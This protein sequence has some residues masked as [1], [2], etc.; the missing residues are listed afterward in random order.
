MKVNKHSIAQYKSL[1]LITVYLI[2]TSLAADAIEL[3][4]LKETHQLSLKITDINYPNELLNKELNS[5]LKSHFH[6]I[7][8]FEKEDEVLTRC[9]YSLNVTYDLW[10]EYYRIEKVDN[11]GSAAI[12]R[13][14]NIQEVYRILK[15][16][17]IKCPLS[18]IQTT[19]NLRIKAQVFVNPVEQKRIEKIKS[20]INTSQEHKDGSE[21][22]M[23]HVNEGSHYNRIISI[24]GKAVKSIMH[25]KNTTTRPRFEK[26]FDKILSQYTGPSDI[27]SLWKSKV[28]TKKIKLQQVNNE[29]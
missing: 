21:G 25:G 11:H 28:I 6:S 29:K 19:N 13:I 12:L 10:D 15:N 24:D 20:W 27:I 8:S 26:L 22:A 3:S 7:I 17:E 1:C 23:S 18:A 2:G 14:T 4:V 5:G 16:L 9:A